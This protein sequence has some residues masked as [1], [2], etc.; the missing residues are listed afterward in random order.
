MLCCALTIIALLLTRIARRKEKKETNYQLT[1][2][3][4]ACVLA[5][6]LLLPAFFW[7][8][9]RISGSQL[10]LS[11][12]ET[13]GVLAYIIFCGYLIPVGT[14]IV[15]WRM[16]RS[17]KST[18]LAIKQQSVADESVPQPPRYQPG[19]VI[20]FVFNDDSAWG[21]LEY[22]NGN[23]QG[24]RLALKREVATLGRD[25]ICDIWLDDEMASRHHAE[26][27][28]LEG[29][30]YLTDCSS[31]NGVLLNGQPVQGTMLVESEQIIQIGA[32]QFG[33]T[34]DDQKEALAD[35]YDPLINHTWRS[36]L[37]LRTDID[38]SS[39][40]AAAVVSSQEAASHNPMQ[41]T[42]IE[43]DHAFQFPD[44]AQRD[45][46]FLI[47][48]GERVGQRVSLEGTV[49]TIGRSLECTIILNDVS[50]AR[51]HAQVVRQADGLILH[52]MTN[53][54]NTFLNEEILLVPQLL[55][56]GDSVRVG[57]IHLEYGVLPRFL[58]TTMPPIPITKSMSGPVPLRLPSKIKPQ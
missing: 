16:T 36:T 40:L 57:N 25:E 44:V 53:Y 14:I 52:D 19:K 4:A 27:A 34:L 49:V 20:P 30:V 38:T 11:L 1:V 45:G 29:K 31:L 12:I 21:W 51:I 37:D 13:R 5:A 56:A 39:V 2:T 28:W 35:R 33:F 22:Q 26:I 43:T 10:H 9:L 48:D 32:Q 15:Y 42:L 3:M 23:F 50:V 54:H 55:R 7:F 17:R 24:Q 18:A 8:H 6:V 58:N 41:R 47:K 46:Y